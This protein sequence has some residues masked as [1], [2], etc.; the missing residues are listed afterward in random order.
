M[1]QLTRERMI[2][3]AGVLGADTGL[4]LEA[5]WLGGH[6]PDER[7]TWVVICRNAGFPLAGWCPPLIVGVANEP[8]L[9]TV[10][11]LRR[12]LRFALQ[13][14]G[15]RPRGFLLPDRPASTSVAVSERLIRQFLRLP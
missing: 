5:G 14:P 4:D 2:T 12:A 11:G 6:T 15:V 7:D 10:D 13:L 3:A 8:D 9:D 1:D